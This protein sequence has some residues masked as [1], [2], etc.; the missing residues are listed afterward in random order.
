M[1]FPD[2]DADFSAHYYLDYVIQSPVSAATLGSSTSESGSGWHAKIHTLCYNFFN[3]Y[4]HFL[5]KCQCIDA[6][7]YLQKEIPGVCNGNTVA[8]CR[9]GNI[10]AGIFPFFHDFQNV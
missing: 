8:I 7:T 1:V 3:G 9:A 5:S 4:R 2:M 6:Q 10:Q